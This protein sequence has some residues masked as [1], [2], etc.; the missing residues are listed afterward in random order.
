MSSRNL[1][2]NSKS[3]LVCIVLIVFVCSQLSLAKSFKVELYEP[4][5]SD[6]DG[7]QQEQQIMSEL[8]L[9]DRAL[10]RVQE[11]KLISKLVASNKDSS[12]GFESNTLEEKSNTNEA[13]KK[14]FNNDLANEM[15]PRSRLGADSTFQEELI[16]NKL[17]S[18][19]GIKKRGFQI[20]TYY[21]A[22]IQ[23]DGSILLIPKD[24]NKN[25]YF[26]G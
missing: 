21:D 16:K 23:N 8:G 10:Q 5:A 2:K 14:K 7:E 25:H 11:A 22:L 1:L 24:V 3:S 19:F 15:T 12:I 17:K 26:I 20:Q 4:T 9:G 13:L 6:V 18:L